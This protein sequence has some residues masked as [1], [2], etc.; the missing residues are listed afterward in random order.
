MEDKWSSVTDIQKKI[1]EMDSF[2]MKTKQ[3]N[4]DYKT[5][6]TKCKE[7]FGE[8]IDDETVFK[9]FYWDNDFTNNL[10]RLSIPYFRNRKDIREYFLMYI[11]L[12]VSEN[13]IKKIIDDVRTKR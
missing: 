9:K 2:I 10:I 11:G 6:L 5:F 4:K 13:K 12:K 3:E 8:L 1:F 7:E